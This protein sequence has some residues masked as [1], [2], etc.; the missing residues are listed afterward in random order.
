MFEAIR[1]VSGGDFGSALGALEKKNL[2]TTPN[3]PL[4]SCLMP[5]E[6]PLR[7]KYLTDY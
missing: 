2:Q 7:G 6:T 3:K 4:E 1:E 5:Y